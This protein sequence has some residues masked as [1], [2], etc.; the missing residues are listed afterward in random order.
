MESHRAKAILLNCGP[1]VVSNILPKNLFEY[2]L[3]LLCAIY[4]LASNLWEKNLWRNYA[5]ELPHCFVKYTSYWYNKE[6]I[7]Y[8]YHNLLHLAADAANFGC[9]DS[10]SAFPLE[11]YMS[12]GK[13]MIRSGNNRLQKD[14]NTCEPSARDYFPEVRKPNGTIYTR[15]LWQRTTIS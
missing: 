2:V 15:I 12:R 13:E 9:V 10:F 14:C 11:I 7:I 3:L 1:V 5:N 8:S 4:I 6:L